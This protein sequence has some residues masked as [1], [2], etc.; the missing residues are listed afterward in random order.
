MDLVALQEQLAELKAQEQSDFEALQAANAV[1]F[2]AETSARAE[3]DR[4]KQ[5]GLSGIYDTH[6]PRHL[7]IEAEY[8]NLPQ[9]GVMLLHTARTNAS[10]AEARAKRSR[11][12]SEAAEKEFNE[13]REEVVQAALAE[14]RAGIVHWDRRFHTSLAIGN[15]AAFAAIV[16]HV[17]DKDT[18]QVAIRAATTALVIFATGLVTSGAIPWVLAVELRPDSSVAA[19]A[20]GLESR[21]RAQILARISAGL[22]VAGIV[23]S[24][25]GA[26]YL[27]WRSSV[28]EGEQSISPKPF[29][30]EQTKAGS[31]PTSPGTPA[32][33][34]LPPSL[35]RRT[36]APP[37]RSQPS[38]A[39]APP[40]VDRT[41]NRG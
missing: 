20:A 29:P 7:F 16:N 22:F 25:A 9:E 38:G 37:Q 6:G 23:A 39:A 1:L 2:G 15:G 26:M 31:L 35:P 3:N 32:S 18:S 27:G 5:L 17:F 12:E 11:S 4:R 21:R 28:A 41:G 24:L 30:A 14:I 34:P 10:E 33:K 19:L 13:R 8:P 36:P 40:A